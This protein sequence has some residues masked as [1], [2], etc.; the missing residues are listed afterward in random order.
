MAKRKKSRAQG[1]PAPA[2]FRHQPFSALKASAGRLPAPAPARP[3]PPPPPEPAAPESEEDLFAAAVAD[4]R[5]IT[6]RPAVPRPPRLPPR[7]RADQREAEE[8]LQAL[9][10]LVDGEA[11]LSIYETDE[12]IE[13]LADGAD[14]R[15]LRQL[16]RGELAI[17]D[18]LDL[19]GLTR[20]E[21][22]PVV[23]R[24]LTEAMAQGKRGVLIV[25]G[26]GHGSKDHIPVLK[27][28]LQTWL[29]RASIRKHILAFC[30]ARPCDGG[31]GALYVLLRRHRPG[32]P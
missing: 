21:A 20:E 6:D 29:V 12:A 28:A 31:A 17:Q 30:T 10:D 1:A 13:G 2:E 8:V 18:H 9:Q 16:K 4:A 19:H 32:R 3:A 5:P 25:H 14:P 27:H 23:D 22:K 26:R 7:P 24:F 15:L 11:P